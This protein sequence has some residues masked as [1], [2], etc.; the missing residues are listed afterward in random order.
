MSTNRSTHKE[1]VVQIYSELLLG[2]KKEEWNKVIG[3]NINTEND[4]I[5]I[6]AE[7]DK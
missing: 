7:R 6:Q 2:H 5:L 1:D 3:C 4:H